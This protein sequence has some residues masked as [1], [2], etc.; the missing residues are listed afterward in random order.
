MEIIKAKKVPIAVESN[1]F[2][3]VASLNSNKKKLSSLLDLKTKKNIKDSLDDDFLKQKIKAEK[4]LQ[5]RVDFIFNK[6]KTGKI[7][8]NFKSKSDFLRLIKKINE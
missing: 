6:N 1:L 3:I 7:I 8:L 2:S 4:K 5:T